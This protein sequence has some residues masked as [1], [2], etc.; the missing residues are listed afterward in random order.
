MPAHRRAAREFWLAGTERYCGSQVRLREGII[1]AEANSG[2]LFEATGISEVPRRVLE[3]D[4]TGVGRSKV[5][6]GRIYLVCDRCSRTVDLGLDR[7]NPDPIF[8]V[9]YCRRCSEFLLR[10]ELDGGH[11]SRLDSTVLIRP[12][13]RHEAR[14]EPD[15]LNVPA[16]V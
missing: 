12:G 11:Q 3:R 7:S 8:M 9:G 13:S 14:T 1:R 15:R 6:M 10:Q 4:P 16:G 5:V 2:G